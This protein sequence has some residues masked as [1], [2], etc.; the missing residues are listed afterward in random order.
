M[1]IKL[2][3]DGN[4]QWRWEYEAWDGKW[5]P[6]HGA[7]R[8]SSKELATIQAGFFARFMNGTRDSYKRAQ[9]TLHEEVVEL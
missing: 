1:K 6:G 2:I 4:H 7:Q 8:Y 5:R 3:E 9:E